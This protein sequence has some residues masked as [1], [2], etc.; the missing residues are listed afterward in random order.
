MTASAVRSPRLY[1]LIQPIDWAA[2]TTRGRLVEDPI[3]HIARRWKELLDLGVSSVQLDRV[4]G[5]RPHGHDY[6]VGI[7]YDGTVVRCSPMSWGQRDELDPLSLDWT[8]LV[9]LAGENRARG[10]EVLVYVGPPPE[11]ARN[12]QYALREYAEPALCL[13][14]S[15]GLDNLAVLRYGESWRAHLLLAFCAGRRIKVYGEPHNLKHPATDRWYELLDGMISPAARALH[16]MNHEAEWHTPRTTNGESI[17]VIDGSTKP[18]ERRGLAE[19]LAMLGWSVAVE[20][21]ELPRIE[22]VRLVQSFTT[23]PPAP[24]ET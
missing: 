21:A 2:P 9:P 13:Q 6:R 17:A 14:A 16:V 1:G 19:H 18:R 8:R 5:V 3:G 10:G 23:K 11:N 12:I 24:A 20:F 7:A 22:A 15:L 4:A